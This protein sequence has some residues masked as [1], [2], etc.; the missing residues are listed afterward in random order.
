M[1]S[2]DIKSIRFI[3]ISCEISILPGK[4]LPIFPENI[5]PCRSGATTI[6]LTFNC[7]G[8]IIYLGRFTFHCDQGGIFPGKIGRI[9]PGS[10]EISQEMLM[11][12]HTLC[13]FIWQWL[14]ESGFF[15]TRRNVTIVHC[16]SKD[17]ICV[18]QIPWTEKNSYSQEIFL[19]RVLCY[20]CNKKSISSKGKLCIRHSKSYKEHS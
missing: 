20:C 12:N 2:F 8:C 5:P 17:D 18:Q 15:C 6:V 3:N 10:I 7:F 11:K 13:H 1:P 9:F 4:I 14:H 16:I 19:V